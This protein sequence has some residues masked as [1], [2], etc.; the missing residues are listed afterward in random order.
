MKEESARSACQRMQGRGSVR[1]CVRPSYVEPEGLRT[2]G[3]GRDSGIA[4]ALGGR[5]GDVSMEH[6]RGNDKHAERSL[7]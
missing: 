3:E 1:T 5:G 6:A 7:G 2:T 4:R